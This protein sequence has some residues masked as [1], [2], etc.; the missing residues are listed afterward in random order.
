MPVQARAEATRRRILD[1]ATELFN[2]LGYGETGLADVL[3]RAGVS[4]GAFYYHF[5]SKEALARAIIDTFDERV[6]QVFH[7]DFDPHNPTLAGIIRSTFDVQALLRRDTMSHIGH[8]LCQALGQVCPSG[9]RVYQG[10]TDRFVEMVTMV[11]TTG[12]L[13]DDV[14]PKDVA[15]AIWVSVL[16]CHLVSAAVGDDCFARLGRSWRVLL[17]SALPQ[18]AIADVD[19]LLDRIVADYQTAAPA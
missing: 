1:S 14:D 18:R 17:R 2:E 7:G 16:G 9:A 19:D 12:E 8:L 10:W 4:K 11:I 13:R 6:N 5:D 15:E 3:Q